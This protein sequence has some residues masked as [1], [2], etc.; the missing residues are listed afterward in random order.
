MKRCPFCAEEIQ[1]AAIVCKHCHKDVGKAAAAGAAL[2][3]IGGIL[4]LV[5]TLRTS[6]SGFA[7]A[8]LYV[9][10]GLSSRH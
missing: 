2:K 3:A 6:T 1:D 4:T 7:V 5:I 8:S 10:R 9:S